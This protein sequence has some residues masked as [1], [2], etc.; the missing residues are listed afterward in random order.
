MTDL[1]A[2]DIMTKKVIT[3]NQD[4]SIE[5]L[6]GLL[7]DNNISG[8]PV[9]DNDGKMIGIATEGDIIVKDTDLHFPRYFKLLDSIIYLESLTKFKNSLKKH[10]AIKVSEIM[11]SDIIS[12]SPETPVDDIANTM[13][14][15]KIN[16]IPVLSADGKPAGI[17]TRADI[18]KSMVRGK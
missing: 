16:R 6:S 7:L 5:E 12:C 1:L 4:A 3:I 18:I 13:V 10:L 9:V 11:T 14:E 8:V 15:N 17:I 2:K